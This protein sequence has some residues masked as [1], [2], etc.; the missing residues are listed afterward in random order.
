MAGNPTVNI[1]DKTS[2]AADGNSTDVGDLI[3]GRYGSV[4]Q[5]V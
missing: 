2:F 5:Q 3:T 4:G 1:I